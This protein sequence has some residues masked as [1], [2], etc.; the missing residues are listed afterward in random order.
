MVFN[1]KELLQQY[2]NRCRFEIKSCREN[3]SRL[4][5]AIQEVKKSNYWKG[6]DK[7]WRINNIKHSIE[8]ERS[9]I[10]EMQKRI[11]E[12]KLKKK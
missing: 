5:T 6:E 1:T 4:Q 12:A 7:I 3:I 2:V 9:Q 8:W 11:K 10:K